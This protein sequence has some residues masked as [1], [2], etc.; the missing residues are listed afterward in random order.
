MKLDVVAWTLCTLARAV[1]A[2][3]QDADLATLSRRRVADLAEY[4]DPSW[5]GNISTWIDAQK[6]DGTWPDVNY[7]SGCPA[8][9]AN[10]PIQD[11]W[12]RIITLAAA[13]RGNSSIA[14]PKWTNSTRA[15]DAISMGLDYWF[16]NDYKPAAC[17]GDGGNPKLGCPCGTPGLWNGNWYDQAILIPQLSSA[18]CL[19]A[20]DGNLS[21]EQREGCIRLSRRTYDNIDLSYG[22]GGILTAANIVLVLQS[23]VTLGLF[24]DNATVVEDAMKRAFRV[25]TFSDGAMQ[26]GIHRDGSFLQHT[27][28]LYNGNY[29]KDLLNI[30]IQFEG[31]AAGTRFAAD[32]ATREAMSTYIKGDEW[33]IFT[34]RKARQEHWDFNVIGRFVSFPTQDFQASADI[35]VNVTKLARAVADFAGPYNVTSTIKRLESNGTEPL[36][37]NKGFWASDYMASCEAPHGAR[38]NM[39]S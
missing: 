19:L 5:F 11:H 31:E 10:W 30:F 17:L 24:T 7:L 9:H 29:G 27:G 4:P 26:D 12:N 6:P 8:Q 16:K 14:D 3:A 13:W 39:T 33:M 15:W 35:N 2:D 28:I 32:N 38:R 20:Q 22:S 21:E 1:S 34:D 37:G 23:S 36:V 25:M 18:A